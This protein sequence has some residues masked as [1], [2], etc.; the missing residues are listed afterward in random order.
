MPI[1]D[2][3]TLGSQTYRLETAYA[4]LYYDATYPIEMGET[5]TWS[6]SID[7]IKA[8]Y[9]SH[10]KK[11]QR[12]RETKE[13][14]LETILQVME[15]WINDFSYVRWYSLV[16]TQNWFAPLRVISTQILISEKF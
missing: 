4:I 3:K 7:E 8:Y 16:L 15:S 5:R 1:L 10:G 14:V 13:S 11:H 12:N 6:P 9:Q 2:L